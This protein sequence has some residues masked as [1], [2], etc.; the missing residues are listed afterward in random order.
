[1]IL[2]ATRRFVERETGNRSEVAVRTIEATN[3]L[4]KN[5]YTLDNTNLPY[6]IT[7]VGTDAHVSVHRRS[8]FEQSRATR[9]PRWITVRLWTA[10][11]GFD[12]TRDR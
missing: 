7:Y 6:Y 3:N 12:S 5:A 2:T 11:C 9:L 8:R 1:M 4:F 10:G